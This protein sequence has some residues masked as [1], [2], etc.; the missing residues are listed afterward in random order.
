[1]VFYLYGVFKSNLCLPRYFFV[2]FIFFGFTLLPSKLFG[3]VM[4]LLEVAS[5]LQDHCLP[6]TTVTELNF[7]Q[8]IFSTLLNSFYQASILSLRVS[9]RDI[10]AQG[11]SLILLCVQVKSSTCTRSLLVLCLIYYIY[12]CYGSL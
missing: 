11:S 6:Q 7:I 10:L 8:G 2:A 3:N 1:M 12:T 9:V 5:I 4:L